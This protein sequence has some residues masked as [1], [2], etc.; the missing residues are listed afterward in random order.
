[1]RKFTAF[2][3][4]LLAVVLSSPV[5]AHEPSPEAHLDHGLWWLYHLQYDKARADFDQYIASH[6]KDP[7]GYFY[8]TATNW[9]HLAQEFEYQLP[10]VQKQFLTDADKT[11]A[12][13]HTLHD[14]TD[15]P[16]VRARALLYWG[17]AEGL[18]GRWLVTQRQWVS[19]YFA[20]K[21]GARYLRR[22]IALDPTQYDAYMGLGIY[23][24][25]TDT[26]SGVQAVLAALLIHGDRV[27]G[28]RELQ[29]A[30]DKSEHA[31]VEAMTFLIE[32]YN[33]EEKTPAKALPLARQLHNEFPKSPAMHL[34]LMST[35][36]VMKE[37]DPAVV[38]AKDI[39][40]KS[41]KEIPWYTKA[42]VRPAQYCIGVG[43]L[44]GKHDLNGAS[45]QL[46]KILSGKIDENRWVTFAL[47][48]QGQIYD[49]RGERDKAMT[50]YRQVLAR[51]DTW[52]SHREA[53]LYLKAPFTF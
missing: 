41:E 2:M 28:L 52:E 35:L 48:R 8:R 18:R 47:L 13:A 40:E 25:F 24:Y 37:W 27:R 14:S 44:F 22:A 51:L 19:A 42:T 50:N 33:A 39:L 23:D 38:E 11:I 32:I 6:P 1:M 21:R 31:R 49:L 15:D 4:L 20:G 53:S 3:G 26:M 46:D 9:W 7:E 36:Y 12:V 30:I 5:G 29:I 10:V 34:M 16:K 43:L 45:E 17:G